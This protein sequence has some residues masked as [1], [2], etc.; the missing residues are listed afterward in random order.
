MAYLSRTQTAGNRRTWTQSGWYKLDGN[1]PGNAQSL[2][3]TNGTNTGTNFHYTIEKGGNTGGASDT[4]SCHNYGGDVFTTTKLLRD[5]SAWYHIV[6]AMDTTQVSAADRI[7]LWVNNESVTITQAANYPIQDFEFGVNNNG[8]VLGIGTHPGSVGGY[9][10]TGIQA[11]VQLVDGLAL[12]PAYFGSTDTATGIWKPGGSSTI[13]DYG[14]NGFKLKMDTT[15]PGADTSGKGNN[16]AVAAGTFTLTQGSPSNNWATWN[17]L[18]KY[19]RSATFANGNTTVNSDNNSL[20]DSARGTFGFEKGKW[21]WETKF[22]GSSAA[23]NYIGVCNE[24]AI[25]GTNDAYD[26]NAVTVF[27]NADGGEMRKDGNP[28]SANYGTFSTSEVCGVAVDA[29]NNTISIYKNNSIIV[30]N[31]ALSTSSIGNNGTGFIF[32]NA[33]VLDNGS[34]Q[35]TNFGEGF[36]GTVAAG[37]SADGNGQG[38]FA[39]APPSGYYAMNTKNLEAYG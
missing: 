26:K 32:P 10:F 23:F 33:A 20:W 39:Y 21:Y 11:M 22:F 31:Y 3:S 17:P 2:I 24:N 1:D 34:G 28:T 14:T 18:A 27:Y 37:T 13:S 29:D 8:T 12:T 6:L 7:K 35:Y 38:L 4:I 5:Y 9:Q 25:M 15:T 19:N 16:Y 30:T 36:F